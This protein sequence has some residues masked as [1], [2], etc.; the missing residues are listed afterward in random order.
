MTVKPA[1]D[2]LAEMKKRY[3]KCPEGWRVLTGMD[4]KD[5]YDTFISAGDGRVWQIKSEPISRNELVGVGLKV[6]K[7]DR[8]IER[9]MM[10]GAP[11]PFGII[12]PQT[13]DL[14]IIMAGIQQYS[15]N[16]IEQLKKEYISSKQTKLYSNL[17]KEVERMLNSDPSLDRKY[18]AYKEFKARSYV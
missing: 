13:R 16:A 9:I 12:S 15:S 11:V 14:A 5:V 2:I 7:V 4:S 18:R 6:E 8:E 10:S 17:K 3:D 1:K